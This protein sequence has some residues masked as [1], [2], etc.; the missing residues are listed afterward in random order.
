MSELKLSVD[1]SLS[2]SKQSGVPHS[3]WKLNYSFYKRFDWPEHKVQYNDSVPTCAIFKGEQEQL[4]K[5]PVG[6]RAVNVIVTT[7]LDFHEPEIVFKKKAIELAKAMQLSIQEPK[8][9]VL[10]AQG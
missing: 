10:F 6:Q 8:K 7:I 5:W 4:Y 2:F 1:S 3:D 9:H